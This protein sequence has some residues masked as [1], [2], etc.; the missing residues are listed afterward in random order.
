[1]PEFRVIAGQHRTS[2]TGQDAGTVKRGETFEDDR[3]LDVL[4]A[5]KFERVGEPT[6]RF[7]N[8][9]D[10]LDNS[11][12]VMDKEEAEKSE[13]MKAAATHP[14]VKEKGKKLARGFGA[15]SKDGT[16]V[17]GEELEP[18]DDPVE[19]LKK[20]NKKT[21]KDT[22]EEEEATDEE[23]AE[24]EAEEAKEHGKKVAQSAEKKTKKA[25]K[26]TKK[27]E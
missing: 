18:E 23:Q 10:S 17:R 13:K 3:D 5:G 15:K 14:G 26:A 20:L 25:K 16:R 4:F 24:E 27:G 2:G 8:R 9:D 6:K 7:R 12:R 19:L 1:M 21:K 11:G 22:A